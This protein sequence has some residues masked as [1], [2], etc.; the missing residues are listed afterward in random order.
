MSDRWIRSVVSWHRRAHEEYDVAGIES[1]VKHD[2]CA[3][4]VIYCRTGVT[5][6]SVGSQLV[7]DGFKH[8]RDLA[9]GIT[10][11]QDAGYPTM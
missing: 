10:A 1:L 2:P 6:Q 11:W 8:V 3:N 9:G 7:A 4:I 5:S